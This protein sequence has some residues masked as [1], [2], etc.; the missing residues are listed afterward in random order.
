[1]DRYVA[2]KPVRFDRNY[3]V[4]ELIAASVIDPKTVKRIIDWGKIQRV[5]E[6]DIPTGDDPEKTVA[7][8]EE[9]LG[10]DRS[11]AG[12]DMP[13]I[14]VRAAT[15]KEVIIELQ[16]AAAQLSAQ[17]SELNEAGIAFVEGLLGISYGA[18]EPPLSPEE[19]TEAIKEVIAG[20]LGR[21]QDNKDGQDDSDGEPEPEDDA[22]GTD[23]PPDPDNAQDGQPDGHSG[24]AGTPA[25]VQTVNLTTGGGAA[26]GTGDG[27]ATDNTC[28]VC[29]RV[30][31]SK[32]ALTTHMKKEHPEYKA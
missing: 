8:L 12:D 24:A 17:D 20:L 29:G 25:N 6:P 11:D 23:T 13:D 14:E 28:P 1:M 19:R 21:Q 15:C 2:I 31:G 32:A 22:E 16:N 10:I 7:F 30:M 9:I 5:I 18:D 4:G 26:E 27:G 3:A